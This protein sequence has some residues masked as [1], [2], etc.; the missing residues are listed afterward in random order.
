MPVY[1]HTNRRIWIVLVLIFVNFPARRTSLL[2][3]VTST[4]LKSSS[5]W[6]RRPSSSARLT[7]QNRR[8][9]ENR[10]REEVSPQSIWNPISDCRWLP[11][12]C[13]SSSI[14]SLSA[15]AL[16]PTLLFSLLSSKTRWERFSSK[17][18][19]VRFSSKTRWVRISSK[20]RWV[21]FFFQE[22]GEWGV[23]QKQGEWGFLKSLVF[24][25]YWIQL[26]Q[27]RTAKMLWNKTSR[28][29]DSSRIFVNFAVIRV[30]QK[31]HILDHFGEG[32]QK[33]TT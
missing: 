5:T 29:W 12:M 15:S 21:R 1:K 32:I 6:R 10:V 14:A 8:R 13:S 23:L 31:W 4:G 33:I 19:W 17:T 25:N 27:Q 16:S 9:I 26:L 3:S 28:I 30:S 18:R 2:C 20:T 11:K 24:Q 22:Q 7:G